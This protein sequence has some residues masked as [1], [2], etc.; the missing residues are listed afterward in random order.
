LNAR[1][2]E[3]R[4]EFAMRVENT[5]RKVA[6]AG[7]EQRKTWWQR[8]KSTSILTGGESQAAEHGGRI[9]ARHIGF[10]WRQATKL[11]KTTRSKKF[12]PATG[13]TLT[14]SGT[15][16]MPLSVHLAKRKRV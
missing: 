5:K 10:P 13:R 8:N 9:E 4:Y 16:C 15:E 1:Q 7:A 14:N 12:H 6:V 2:G 3:D 11:Q